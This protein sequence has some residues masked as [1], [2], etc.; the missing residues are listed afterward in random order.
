MRKFV[1]LFAALVFSEFAFGGLAFAADMAVKAPPPPPVASPAYN[2]T[3]FYVGLNAGYRLDQSNNA[4]VVGFTDPTGG[5]GLGPAIAAGAVP[6]TSYNTAGF[7]GGAQLGYNWQFDP[8]WVLGVETDFM[9]RNLKGSETVVATPPGFVTNMTTV[10][11]K[12]D[13]LGTTRAKAGYAAGN[14]LF[15]GTGGVAYG[16]AKNSLQLKLPASGITLF[17]ANSNVQT[18]WTA[19]GGVEYGWGAWL[20]R[21]E[22]LHYDL[23]SE[24]IT[25]NSVINFASPATLSVS[26]KDTGNIVRGALS[27][28]F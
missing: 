8:H 24:T 7:V 18:G 1:G 4:H 6:V 22:Y 3:G 10:T 13:W 12:L 25:T 28:R 14:W 17:G 11:Q 20:I 23:G 2:W 26:Q 15:Y 19:G 5:F 21:A 9:S 27:Y 16:E